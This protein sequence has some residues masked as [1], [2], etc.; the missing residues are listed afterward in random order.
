MA[1]KTEKKKPKRGSRAEL[2]VAKAKAKAQAAVAV[3]TA[4]ESAMRSIDAVT[5]NL[6]AMGVDAKYKKQSIKARDLMEN[7]LGN[8]VRV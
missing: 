1:K 8:C 4:I 7:L 3:C 5:Y 2:K 6:R